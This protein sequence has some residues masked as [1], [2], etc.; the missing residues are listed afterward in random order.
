M[1]IK[2]FRLNQLRL[3]CLKIKTSLECNI[4]YKEKLIYSLKIEISRFGIKYS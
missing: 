2:I 1:S 3:L 4:F